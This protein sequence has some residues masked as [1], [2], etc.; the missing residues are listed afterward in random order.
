MRARQEHQAMAEDRR[1]NRVVTPIAQPPT[2]LAGGE[3]IAA[4]VTI[5][6]E[7]HLAA[8]LPVLVNRCAP[9]PNF[10][11]RLAPDLSAIRYTIGR[12]E[13]FADDIALHHHQPLAQQRR[14]G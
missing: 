5:A 13:L 4:D 9:R 2:L 3:F 10:F 14:T 6:V 11:P 7:N 8:S 1:W 12:H